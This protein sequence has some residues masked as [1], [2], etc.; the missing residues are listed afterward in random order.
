MRDNIKR[1]SML[2]VYLYQNMRLYL[3]LRM[4]AWLRLRV[5]SDEAGEAVSR[6]GGVG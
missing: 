6:A 3:R 2:D 5:G 4:P 1:W